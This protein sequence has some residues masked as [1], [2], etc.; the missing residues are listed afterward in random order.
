M[1]K[2]ASLALGLLILTSGIIFAQT[3]FESSPKNTF[4]VDVGPT[5]I[6]LAVGPVIKVV[7]SDLEGNA[8][9]FGIGAQYER[10]INRSWSAAARFA[11]LG[12]GLGLA[13]E[14]GIGRAE[15]DMSMTSYSVEGHVRLYPFGETFFVDG[16]LGYAN[17]SA[18][19]TGNVMIS[20][21][22][23]KI[24]LPVSV[25]FS[26]SR[27]YF[28]L[29]AKAG[30]RMYLGKQGTFTFEPSVGYSHGIGLGETIEKQLEKKVGGIVSDF[31][32]TFKYVENLVF[33]GGPRVSLAFG[34]RL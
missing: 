26:P 34:L 3:D 17:L 11:Y 31:E 12:A 20:I 2:R 32:D 9:G 10:Q 29:G 14:E 13:M 18:N 21:G 23:V 7:A 19:L 22:G 25:S 28:K 6:G 15:L 16:M 8:T 5:I 4:T 24:P 27:N 33:I 30:W 1:T